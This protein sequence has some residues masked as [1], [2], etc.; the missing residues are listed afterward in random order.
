MVTSAIR[1]L[2]F[3]PGNH[4]AKVTKVFTSGADV[5]I[6][7]LE[8]SVALS[9]KAATRTPVVEGLKTPRICLGYVRVNAADTEFYTDD[10]SAVV[11]PWLDGIVLPKVE[12][13]DQLVAA[14]AE[15][16]RLEEASDMLPGAI[17]IIPI[18]ETAKGLAAVSEI[19]GCDSR[20]R[21]LSFGAVDFAKDLGMRLSLDEWELTPAR[22]S[23]VL[24]SRVAGLDAPLDSVWVH[25]KDTDGLVASAERVRDMG[26][27]G[28]MCIH[29]AQIAPVNGVFTPSDEEVA[30]AET[31]VA[32]F[33]EAEAAG[34]ASIQI[35]GFFIDY[36]V[37]EQARRTLN[38]IKSIRGGG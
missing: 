2:L 1:S 3:T 10:L 9:E 38:L 22:S 36:P 26:F 28:K 18:L 32:A 29:P 20:V 31:I 37:V 33:E 35:D 27:R 14:D 6:L 25:F 16:R 15:V 34:S 23:I 21:K 13:A 8:D 12:S 17:D 4:P 11:G 7:D 5:A 19:A 24:A 30:R